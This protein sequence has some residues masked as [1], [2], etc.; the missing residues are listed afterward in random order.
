MG[1][2][3][4]P[5]RF[6]LDRRFAELPGY[7]ITE[8]IDSGS[9]GHVFR[10]FNRDTGGD[11]AVKVVP[12]DNRSVDPARVNEAQL[13]NQI[14]HQ[15]VVRYVQ[16]FPFSGSKVECMLFVCEYVRGDN[17]KQ[18]VKRRSD[19]IDVPFV[20]TFLRTMFELLYELKTRRMVH[21]D[22]HAGNVI[23]SP[24]EYDVYQRPSFRV[25]D[26]R[27]LGNRAPGSELNDYLYVAE[28]LRLLLGAVRYTECEGR[29]KYAF[30]VLRDEFMS[31]HLTETDR[32]VD[33][34]VGE[35]RRLLEKMNAIDDRYREAVERPATTLAS[36]FDYPN[37]E[38]IGDSNLLLR[39]LYSDRLLGLAEIRRRSNIVLTGP[40]GCGKTTVYRALSLD[41]L[42]AT[43]DDDPSKVSYVGLYYRCDDLYFAFSR[44]RD[45]SRQDGI[46]VPMHYMVATL[47]AIAIE[48]VFAWGTRHFHNE[49]RRNESGLVA[50]L[51][52]LFDWDVPSG[53][54]GTSVASLLRR[55]RS[56]RRRAAKTQRLLHL[57]RNPIDGYVGPGTLFEAC[58]KIR[59]R[60][61][62]L[63]DRPFYFF[64][65]DYS[66][67]KIT[68]DLQASLN[69]LLMH[70]TNDLFFKLSTE[71]PI[72]FTREDID[73][74]RY[75]ES[76]EYDLV[77][78]GLRYI[79]NPRAQTMG[80][81]QDLF[82]RRF[83]GVR[84]YPVQSLDELLGSYARNESDIARTF[85]NRRGRHP[86]SG[87][88]TIA[89]M[90]SGDI[91]DM[92]RL[93][94]NMVEDCG[95][96]P[97]LERRVDLPRISVREQHR[98]IR[99]S[100]GSFLDSVRTLPRLGPRMADII[101][102]FGK[103]AHSYL[104]YRDSQNGTG[105]PPHQATR[106]EPYGRI[107]IGLEADQ[108]LNELLR[109]SIF[110]EDPGAKSRRNV[111][112]RRFYLRRY[113]IPHFQL[114][115]SHRDSLQLENSEI[116]LLLIEPETFE[117]TKRLRTKATPGN[118][119]TIGGQGDLFND[120]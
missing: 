68:R 85:R 16:M 104:L 84:N 113:L 35:P 63:R 6:F 62:F 83:R 75:V 9:K 14:A 87:V 22:L 43:G 5:V 117:E 10:A 72:S 58:R 90:C 71:S 77:N 76:R 100:A 18:F 88:E 106:I 11:L 30:N 34:L 120:G 103:V 89:R 110:I 3:L 45:P 53:P 46:D 74:K 61:H 39:N 60:L 12:V 40:R 65:D 17:L 38:Q 86:Y 102:A 28:T 54:G 26:F 73:G 4:P 105:N 49:I 1:T 111:A 15:S 93:V 44:Y 27:V 119:K 70:R 47:V 118:E 109:Y 79:G 96:G 78:L 82:E 51:W 64:I 94:G 13:A 97:E 21:G 116:E 24:G 42:M 33:E 23:V 50:D 19:E 91:H 81:L 32:M 107:K 31:R 41:Y 8:H 37:C 112:V 92:I 66:H 69:R 114:T 95:G 48:R 98:S 36:P 80:F 57:N 56:E 29:D 2:R 59:D 115:F 67:P 99:R 55:L 25:T 108:I 7:V 20:E 52:Q 101:S